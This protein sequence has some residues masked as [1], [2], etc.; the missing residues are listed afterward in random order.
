M[1]HRKKQH[2]RTK[3]SPS[4]PETSTIE[5]SRLGPRKP[6]LDLTTLLAET[7]NDSIDFGW[8]ILPPIGREFR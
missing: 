7:P 4:I 3:H 1:A 8:E 6:K 2:T 5:N